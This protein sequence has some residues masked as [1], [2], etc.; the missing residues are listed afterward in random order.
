MY[1][2][3]GY[4]WWIPKAGDPN[5]GFFANGFGGQYVY[6]LPEYESVIV[7]TAHLEAPVVRLQPLLNDFVRPIL[8]AQD[9]R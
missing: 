3:Y 4:L 7:M 9:G 1:A 6:V 2:D 5:A 8:A